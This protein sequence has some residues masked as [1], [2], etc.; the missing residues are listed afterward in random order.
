MCLARNLPGANDPGGMAAVQRL[1][2]EACCNPAHIP[3]NRGRVGV[4]WRRYPAWSLL[5]AH[6]LSAVSTLWTPDGEVP[7]RRDPQ[8]PSAERATD[9]PAPAQ[10]P[11]HA[12]GSEH[13]Q[14]ASARRPTPGRAPDA[15]APTEADR[16]KLEKLRQEILAT[17]ASVVVAN[18]AYG[19]FE[20]AAIHLAATPP[21][22]EEAR[23]ATDAMGALVEGV[24]SRLGEAGPTLKDALA[25]VRLAFVQ[26][27]TS[28]STGGDSTGGEAPATA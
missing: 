24:A 26:M 13:P 6:T 10:A 21:N 1:G 4:Q 23:L 20:L 8:R 7:I 9:R 28:P 18:H 12:P 19:L 16:A 14:E 27:S 5:P 2:L 25:Q 22:L 3:A 11:R 17:P 15:A